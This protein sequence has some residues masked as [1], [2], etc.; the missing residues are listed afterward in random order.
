MGAHPAPGLGPAEG[1]HSP[2][3]PPP[4][5]PRS[6]AMPADSLEHANNNQ[7]KKD[8]PD[9]RPAAPRAASFKTSVNHHMNGE[10][11]SPYKHE[12]FQAGSHARAGKRE[13]PRADA[14]PRDEVAARSVDHCSF[15]TMRRNRWKSFA[16]FMALV[17]MSAM[18]SAVRTNGITTR[19]P[20]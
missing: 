12:G 16:F 19:P 2:G 14:P 17:N 11:L 15:M 3:C 8:K 1:V 4:N 20:A 13:A 18:L 5:A 10:S 7:P 6:S 9:S